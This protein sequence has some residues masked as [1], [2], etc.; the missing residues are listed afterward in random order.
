MKPNSRDIFDE[1]D[2]PISQIRRNVLSGTGADIAAC[3]QKPLIAVANS[4]TEM[5][6]GH[7]HLAALAGRVKEGIL[8]AGG[9]PFEFNVPAPCDGITEGH[10]GMRYVLPQ[11][12]LIADTIETHVRSMR[13]DAVVMVA[14]CDK[15]IPGMLMATARLDLPTIFVTGGPS[16]MAVR[17]TSTYNGS[18]S[19]NDYE[20]PEQKMPCLLSASCGACEIMGTANTYEWLSEALGLALPG[21]AV[22]PAFHADRSR[23]ARWSGERIVAMV[24]SDL[25]ARKILTP[26]ALENAIMVAQALGGSTNTALHLPALAHELGLE[27]GLGD[28]NRF[29]K[30]VPTLLGIAPNGPHGILDLYAAGGVPAVMKRLADALHLHA[31]TVTGRTVGDLLQ[32]ARVLDESVIPDRDRA[33]CPEGGIVA[34]FGNLAPEGSVIKQSAVTERMKSFTGT[35]HVFESEHEALTALRDK[36]IAEGEVL[37]IRNEGPKGGPGMPET[38]AVTMNLSMAGYQNVAMITDGRFSGASAGPCVGHVSPEAA[39][40]GPIAAVQD[41]DRITID[42]PKRMIELHVDQPTLEARLSRVTPRIRELPPGYMKRYV[43]LVVS[44]AKGAYLD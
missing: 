6:P 15:I 8:A 39:A 31:L 4:A 9:V 26:E 38:L 24:E 19:A 23:Y 35:A 1:S 37:V 40:G 5:N 17:H 32:E 14:S 12:E 34:L 33:H 3:A 42:I 36:A 13:F 22:V 11:R 16:T 18:I 44:A 29:S 20:A 27:I 30:Q 21:S 7:M 25:K 10:A 43:K 2:F 41:G 28:F